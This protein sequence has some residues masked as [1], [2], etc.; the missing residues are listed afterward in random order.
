MATYVLIPGAGGVAWYWHLLEAELRARGH[1]VVAV[2]LLV[3]LNAMVPSPGE[4]PGDWW[5]NTGHGRA[6]REQAERD[7][8]DLAAAEDL[9]DAFFH[10][11]LVRPLV[12]A[13]QRH[14]VAHD[15]LA[16]SLI[17]LELSQPTSS[18]VVET[19]SFCTLFM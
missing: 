5:S 9:W 13:I 4:A 15:Q 8:R 16:R 11:V 14:G 7:G 6:R 10:D 1:E 3:M 12:I 2:D 17:K 18:S 19:T